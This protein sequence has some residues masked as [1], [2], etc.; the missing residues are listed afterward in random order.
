MKLIF[1][2]A[3]D[4]AVYRLMFEENKPVTERMLLHLHQK[5][6]SV[7]KGPVGGRKTAHRPSDGKT[8]EP[9][10]IFGYLM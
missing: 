10:S 1:F 8:G 2:R 4:H 7:K 5:L 3:W 9:C 6:R